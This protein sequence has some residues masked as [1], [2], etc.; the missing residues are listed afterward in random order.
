MGRKAPLWRL[1]G[2]RCKC[3]RGFSASIREIVW[4]IAEGVLDRVVRWHRAA[5]WDFFIPFCPLVEALTS[6]YPDFPNSL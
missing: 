3:V 2:L 5:K 4:K 6:A 1:A